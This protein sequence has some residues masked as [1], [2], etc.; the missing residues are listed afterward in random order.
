[1]SSEYDIPDSVDTF[2]GSF[3]QEEDDLALKMMLDELGEV[4]SPLDDKDEV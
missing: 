2:S 3:E 4:D 1:M